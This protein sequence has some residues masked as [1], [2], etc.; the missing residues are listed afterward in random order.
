MAKVSA[1]GPITVAI[2]SSPGPNSV[3]VAY[4][5][6]IPFLSFGSVSITLPGP[7]T[8]VYSDG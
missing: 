1:P 3:H 7:S 8:S 6:A 4:S 5:Q 2:S